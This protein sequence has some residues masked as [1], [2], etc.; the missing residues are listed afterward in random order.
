MLE[1]ERIA[2]EPA[3]KGDMNLD[4]LFA[5]LKNRGRKIEEVMVK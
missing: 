4:E 5:D 1:T 3:V 2:K